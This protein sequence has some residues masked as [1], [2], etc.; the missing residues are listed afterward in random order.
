MGYCPHIYGFEAIIGVKCRYMEI[1]TKKNHC[2][3]CSSILNW[4]S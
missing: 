4:K 1:V 2:V 3:M